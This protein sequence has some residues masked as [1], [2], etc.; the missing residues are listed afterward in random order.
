MPP[1]ISI[2]KDK[3]KSYTGWY[4]N[5]RTGRG[6]K[7]YLQNEKLYAT[8]VGQLTPIAENSFITAKWH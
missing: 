1:S 4:K 6:A 3:L 5:N 2:S 7:F 8:E